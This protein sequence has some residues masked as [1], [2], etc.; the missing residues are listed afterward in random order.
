MN[1]TG[2][3]VIGGCEF[4]LLIANA[5]H[6][7]DICHVVIAA[8]EKHQKGEV[9]AKK[10]DKCYILGTEGATAKY[11]LAEDADAT[12]EDVVASAYRTG[13]FIRNVLKVKEGY[14]MTTAD[15]EALE[16]QGIYLSDMVM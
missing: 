12:S 8:G 2:R 7:I 13:G 6:P 14:T 4:P 11:I 3:E 5:K 1:T 9:L 16:R 10:A 15:E